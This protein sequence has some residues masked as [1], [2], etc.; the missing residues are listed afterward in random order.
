M[1][2][3]APCGDNNDGSFTYTP[4]GDFVGTDTFT[5]TATDVNGTSE[6]GIVT[7]T[8]TPVADVVDDSVTTVEDTPVSGDVS[9]NDTFAAAVTFVIHDDAA[10]RCRG[11]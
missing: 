8:V 5:Y 2:L 11:G 3:A 9:T 1:R 10:K 6:T 7:V 4:S